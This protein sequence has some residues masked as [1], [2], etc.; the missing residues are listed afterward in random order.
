[1]AKEK[2]SPKDRLLTTAS[3]MFYQQGV[4]V[5]INDIIK[6]ADVARMTLYKHFASKEA[7]V[8]A[9]LERDTEAWRSQLAERVEAIAKKPEDKPLAAFK[10]VEETVG[11]KGFRGAAALNYASQTAD[12]KS[13]VHTLARAHDIAVQSLFEGWM[14]AAK[15]KKAKRV[16][17]QLGLLLNGALTTAQL[18]GDASAVK[19]ARAAAQ[20]LISAAQ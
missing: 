9:T 19:E 18:E 20:A 13:E 17:R 7:L 10:A 5:G 1:M 12:S 3:E 6:Q 15:L 2:L 16:S 11:S 8:L 4:N 14:K